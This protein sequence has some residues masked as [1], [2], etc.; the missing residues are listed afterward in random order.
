[1]FKKVIAAL[2]AS[3]VLLSACGDKMSNEAI[4]ISN[5]P[6]FSPDYSEL[7]SRSDLIY[8]GIVDFGPYGMPVA[9]GRFGGPVWETNAKTL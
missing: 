6:L 7:V 4:T 9:N 3:L 1:M 2:A 5:E 8:E